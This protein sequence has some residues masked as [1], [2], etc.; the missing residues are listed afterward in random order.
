MVVLFAYLLIMALSCVEYKDS[1]VS[2]WGHLLGFVQV[3]GSC[4][5]TGTEVR[6]WKHFLALT[7][8]W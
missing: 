8:W 2:T 1:R 4:L 3:G 5:F 7:E 6:M